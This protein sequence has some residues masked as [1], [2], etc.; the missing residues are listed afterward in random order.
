MRD[1]QCPP[2]SATSG[3]D[4]S[5]ASRASVCRGR[6]T[7]VT[8][9]PAAIDVEVLKDGIPPVSATWE[10]WPGSWGRAFRVYYWH[11]DALISGAR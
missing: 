4:R 10:R 8:G 6:R 3:R 5:K 1:A 7:W 9:L 2:P 11:R